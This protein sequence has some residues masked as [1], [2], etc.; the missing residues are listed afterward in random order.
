MKIIRTEIDGEIFYGILEG[1]TVRR[2]SGLPFDAIVEDGRTYSVSDIKLLPPA[3][4]TKIVAI[5]KNYRAHADEMGEG[6]PEEPLLFIKPSTSI[7]GNGDD[8]VY[9]AISHRLDYEG[10]LGVVIGKKCHAVQ[11]GHS[12]EVIFGYT[13]LNDVTARD[14]QKAVSQWTRGKGF[15]TFCPIGPHIETELDA[16]NAPIE[17]RVNGEVKQ[18]SNTNCMTHNVDK[19]VSYITECMT[20]LPGDIIATG[21]P[22]GI[23]PMQRGDTV[24]VEI[25]GIGVL[26]NRIV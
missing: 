23:G 24:E 18:H 11:P 10:E 4:P 25:G 8:V 12:S 5:G 15:D 17:T 14:I 9:P 6:Q 2:L 13:C 7:V 3:E 19:L 1:K 20:L 16:Y 22:E 26:R 21:T